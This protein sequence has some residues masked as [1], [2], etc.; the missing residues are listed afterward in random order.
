MAAVRQRMA[1]Y[2]SRALADR[3]FF[4]VKEYSYG[5]KN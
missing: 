5:G 1:T 2:G 4:G 3:E